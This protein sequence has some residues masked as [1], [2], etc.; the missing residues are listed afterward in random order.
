MIRT[1]N[2]PIQ[3]SRK[4]KTTV[5]RD[6]P[7]I[8]HIVPYHSEHKIA[9]GSYTESQDLK[10]TL[11]HQ[12]LLLDWITASETESLI[13]KKTG[14]FVRK[15]HNYPLNNQLKLL[16]RVATFR[17][18]KQLRSIHTSTQCLAE[19]KLTFASSGQVFYNSVAVRQVDVPTLNGRFGVLPEHVPTVGC[20]KPGV[21]AITEN[22]GSMKKYFVS[23]GIVT[24]NSDSTMQ[25]LAEEAAALDQLD[26]QA[27]KDGVSRA[28][29][30]LSTANT[31]VGKTE[32]Q[33][34]IEAFEEMS[35]ALQEHS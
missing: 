29:S 17:L 11:W 33:I 16:N 32:A 18:V 5:P 19:L 24:V 15:M 22:D 34:A 7:A 20:L 2:E 23:S 4:T 30:E 25:V 13:A 27:V 9:Y 31:E 6:V 26:L 35:R 28:Q 8:G 14:L 10:S 12:N 21:V 3:R 1:S